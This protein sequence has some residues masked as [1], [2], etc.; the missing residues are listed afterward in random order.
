VSARGAAGNGTVVL[1]KPAVLSIMY[2]CL[3]IGKA[4][5]QV[6]IPVPPWAD[7]AA[8][9]EKDCGG[10]TPGALS[11]GTSAAT[12]DIIRKG[13]IVRR[14]PNLHALGRPGRLAP[15]AVPAD[16]PRAVHDASFFIR[17]DGT[18][19]DGPLH[20]A[21]AV[22]TVDDTSVL[23]VLAD[24]FLSGSMRRSQS[25]GVLAAG[26]S[27][28]LSLHFVCLHEGRSKVTVS[29]PLLRYKTAEFS[30]TK[31][32]AT[33]AVREA[34]S[35]FNVAAVED[36]FFA[37]ILGCSLGLLIYVRNRRDR[38]LPPTPLGGASPAYERVPKGQRR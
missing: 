30:F 3:S 6:Q 1:G 35:L 26:E 7:M 33:P 10:G 28:K 25:G 36:V 27:R 38:A 22:V 12:S 29:L 2:E 14:P 37:A 34:A 15:T 21:D 4:T 20:L 16:V 13:V 11:V 18:G 9:F 31:D 19:D 23:R 5:V 24:G 8:S 17:H 32:C